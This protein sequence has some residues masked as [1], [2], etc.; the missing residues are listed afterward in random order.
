MEQTGSHYITCSFSRRFAQQRTSNTKNRRRKKN[1]EKL[2][3]K[4][5]IR[6]ATSKT[7]YRCRTKTLS[8][9]KF[10]LTIFSKSSD[11]LFADE[12]KVGM[13]ALSGNRNPSILDAS[14]KD[15]VRKG[16]LKVVGGKIFQSSW[17]L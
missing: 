14:K 13:F 15:D 11:T 2:P 7:N 12:L 9:F 3:E 1:G 17:K 5:G 4:L 16:K 10:H 6:F 8:Q